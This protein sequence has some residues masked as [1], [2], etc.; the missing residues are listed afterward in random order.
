MYRLI[1]AIWL[2]ATSFALAD[3]GYSTVGEPSEVTWNYD[4]A[5]DSAWAVFTYN[6]SR[7]DS[8]R[9]DPKYGSSSRFLGAYGLS[10][11]SIGN[12]TVDLFGFTGDA[13]TDTA[14]GGWFNAPA[15]S[16][17]D[18]SSDKVDVSTVA[19]DALNA[20]VFDQTFWTGIID[21]MSQNPPYTYKV[22]AKG[23]PTTM[24]FQVGY[25]SP[26]PGTEANDFCLG[27]LIQSQG[28]NSNRKAVSIADFAIA[29]ST[30]TVRP[31]FASAPNNGD[32]LFIRPYRGA[33]EPSDW[34]LNQLYLDGSGL[35]RSDSVIKNVHAVAD[36]N[37]DAESLAVEPQYWN[38]GDTALYQ[39]SGG[40][41]DTTAIKT[42]L[43]GQG[44]DSFMVDTLSLIR[45]RLGGFGIDDRTSSDSTLHV[46]LL[47]L[48]E[49]GVSVPDSLFSKIDSILVSLVYDDG[50]PT[51]LKS[52][53]DKL[54]DEW[55][56]SDPTVYQWFVDLNDDSSSASVPDSLVARMD[57]SLA[58]LQ[59]G[60]GPYVCSLYVYNGSGAITSGRVRM[61]QGATTWADDI[62]SDGYAIF[63]LT[64]GTWYGI[65]YI[66][67][68]QQDTIPQTF[69]ITDDLTDSIS[70]SLHTP[71]AA[72]GDL[73]TVWNYIMDGSNNPVPGVA[74]TATIP[75]VFWPIRYEGQAVKAK[76]STKT[77]NTGK[78]ELQIYPSSLLL[79]TQADS[80]SY[81][82]ISADGGYYGDQGYKVTVPDSTSFFMVPDS[83]Q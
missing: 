64:S 60:N 48:A 9:L 23:S 19:N 56:V 44:I 83:K 4:V 33:V 79:T 46:L 11:D 62:N 29:D 5:L 21:T 43:A 51:D 40:G 25:I 38:T 57:S 75:T 8:I 12:H 69:S 45:Q 22:V 76:V 55:L 72:V 24:T 65:A 20:A 50:A 78:W 53:H 81:W 37:S 14:I 30:F 41:S 73:C 16:T 59:S 58:I 6:G 52:V 35:V 34:T 3:G 71:T 13:W 61:V 74:I 63:G 42:M 31:A 54:G 49:Q 7:Y 47:Q 67:L 32:T 26:T 66:P 10:L 82:Q 15:Y 68:N 77:D 1:L 28:G 39:G 2:L 18:A 27:M 36:V 70:L 80:A 17:F